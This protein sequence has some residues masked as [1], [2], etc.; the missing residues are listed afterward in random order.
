[1]RRG[2][3]MAELTTARRPRIVEVIEKYGKCVELVPLD[4]NFHDISVGIYDND[5]TATVWTFS[6]KPGVDGRISQIRDQLIELG[7]MEAVDGTG[8]QARLSCGL[9][10]NRPLKFL[11]MQAVERPAD[12][13]LPEGAIKD[14]RSPLMLSIVPSQEDGRWVYRIAGEGEAPNR[15]PRLRAV[16]GGFVRYGEMEK[17]GE[18]GVAFPCGHRHDRLA[19]LVLPYARNVTGVEDMLDATALRGQ[20][21]T[22][23]LG[24][25]PPT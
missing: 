3:S 12:Y 23:T 2:E 5:G 11:T 10:H 14:L 1:M 15:G 16:L 7:G 18:D 25:T 4:P 22:G 20:M 19:Q 8:N 17:V 24:F 13:R 21:T 9:L 6:Q